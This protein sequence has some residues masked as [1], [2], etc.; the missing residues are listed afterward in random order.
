MRRREFIAF[1]GSSLAARP[2]PAARPP[3]RGGNMGTLYF[4]V[5]FAVLIA[6]SSAHPQSYPSR[7]IT[8]IVPFPAGGGGTD[9]VARVLIEGMKTSL[10]QPIVVE[11][12]PGAG[13]SLGV[14]RAV[15]AT[16]DGYTLSIGN[17]ASHVGA[18]AAYSVQY[19]VLKDLEPVSRLA[20]SPLMIVTRKGFPA[21]DLSELIA[22]LKAN[23][24]KATAGTLGVGSGAHLCGVYFQNA[25]G[26]RLQFVPYRGGGLAVQDLVGGQIDLMCDQAANAW[27]HV[28]NGLIKAYAVM[29]RARWF[30]APDIPT[31]EELGLAGIYH[32]LWTGVWAPKG[33]P[34]EIIETLNTSVRTSLADPAVRQKLTD[35]GQEMAP[36][37]QQTPEGLGAFHKAE[38]DKWWPII[39]AANIKAQ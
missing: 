13:G 32:S 30:G 24:D 37:D 15:R 17:W 5:A 3:W 31:V 36:L 19:D 7:P 4:A 28:R 18:G 22:W 33:T 39:K 25:I 20:E 2:C 26:T 27:P 29:A 1:V 35:L 11:N 9:A 12:V 8:V 6:S 16:P 23:P 38:I 10:G 34:H 21:K 14:A